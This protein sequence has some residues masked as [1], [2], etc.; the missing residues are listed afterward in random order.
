MT[1]FAEGSE[2]VGV[3]TFGNADT[4]PETVGEASPLVRFFFAALVSGCTGSLVTAEAD[5]L[6]VD[7]ENRG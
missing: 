6:V 4:A 5:M 3:S 7:K 2:G 1:S